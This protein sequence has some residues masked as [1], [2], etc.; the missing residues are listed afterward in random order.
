VFTTPWDPDIE[1]RIIHEVVRL[2]N[3]LDSP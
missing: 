2:A 1:T 3:A